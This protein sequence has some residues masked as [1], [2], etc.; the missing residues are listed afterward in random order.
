MEIGISAGALALLALALAAGG[1]VT[2]FMAGLLGIG[3]GSI[4]VPVLYEV[5][6]ILG[7][8][9]AIRMHLAIGT[10]LAVI[11]PTS[12]KSFAAHRARGAVD[13]ALVRRLAAPV[14]L[15]V[16]GGAVVAS[17]SASAALKWVWAVFASLMAIKLLWGQDGWRLGNDIS[18]SRLVD[19][20]GFFVGLVSTLMSAGGGAYITMLMTLYGR[21]IHQAIGTSSGFGPLIAVPGALGFVW[22]GW[23]AA[24]L[25]AGSLGYVNLI[26]AAVII[27][28]SV[29]AAPWG[30]SFAHGISRRKLEL[31]FGCF[32]AVVAMRYLVDLLG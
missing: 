4:L 6:T 5:W 25:P 11:I 14:V 15:G 8:D 26:G 3:G 21:P 19:L 2:G 30:A 29:L 18:K 28:A 31:G 24:G 23:G 12:L 32:L 7:I 27:S 10:S 16:L 17:V 9:A 22:A 20:Y 1:L 13:P